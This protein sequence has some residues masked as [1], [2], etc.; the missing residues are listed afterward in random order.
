[1]DTSSSVGEKKNSMSTKNGSPVV[2]ETQSV[3]AGEASE[4]YVVD[5]ALEKK[6]LRKFDLTI[7]PTLALMYLFKYVGATTSL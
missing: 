7:L 2:E 4:E 3:A 6:L 5:K 1:M